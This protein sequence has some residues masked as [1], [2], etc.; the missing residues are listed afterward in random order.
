MIVDRTL[1]DT[2]RHGPESLN[3]HLIIVK[4]IYLNFILYYIIWNLYGLVRDFLYGNFYTRLE[5]KKND[6]IA[7]MAT[8][9]KML[10]WFP[11]CWSE[12]KNWSIWGEYVRSDLVSVFAPTDSDSSARH[13]PRLLA[14]SAAVFG[15]YPVI[16]I[17][18]D[19]CDNSHDF[20]CYKRG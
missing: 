4:P 18:T 9:R 3:R 7:I 14:L 13:V 12:M 10:V 8:A 2:K 19:E 20:Y 15:C 11:T 5:R 1:N 6:Q 16:L 17:I